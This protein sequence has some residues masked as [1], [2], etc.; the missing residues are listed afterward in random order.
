M[1]ENPGFSKGFLW[2]FSLSGGVLSA[3]GLIGPG[4][5]FLTNIFLE[6]NQ[7]LSHSSLDSIGKV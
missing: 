7:I 1:A 3:P 2:Y 5:V 4:A 6:I